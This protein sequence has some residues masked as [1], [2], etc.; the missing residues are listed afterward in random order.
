MMLEL[1]RLRVIRR[2]CNVFGV[3]DDFFLHEIAMGELSSSYRHP[4]ACSLRHNLCKEMQ[5]TDSN[6]DSHM[7]EAAIEAT[8]CLPAAQKTQLNYS[9]VPGLDSAGLALDHTPHTSS[10]SNTSHP[11]L[12]FSHASFG[13]KDQS[14]KCSRVGNKV[15]CA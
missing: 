12:C 11:S 5:H 15:C 3:S 4:A 9:L 10:Q 14:R 7:F 1:L 2:I 6:Q 8:P 13:R